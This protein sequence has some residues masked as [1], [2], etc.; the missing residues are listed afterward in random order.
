MKTQVII[1]ASIVLTAT[2]SSAVA[3]AHGDHITAETML[4]NRV[5]EIIYDDPAINRGIHSYFNPIAA[6]TIDKSGQFYVSQ[7][8]GPAIYSYPS[9]DVYFGRDAGEASECELIGTE[10]H[11][12]TTYTR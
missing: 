5:V 10:I 2:L 1:T 11:C 4:K 9:V 12:S 8:F 7:A 6:K 3:Y